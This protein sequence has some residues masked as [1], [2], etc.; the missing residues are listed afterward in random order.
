MFHFTAIW[1]PL[2][3]LALFMLGMQYM[4]TSINRLS[5]RSFKLFLKKY[6]S[7]KLSAIGGGTLITA[8]LQ[9]SSIVNLLVLA[10]V[11]A[12]VLKL[13]QA[14]SVILGANLGTTFTGWL[15][16]WLG[17]SYDLKAIALPLTAIGGLVMALTSREKK[18]FTVS[19]L[20]FSLGLIF[21]GL[22]FIKDGTFDIIKTGL[23]SGVSHY[24]LLV[25]AMAGFAFTSII[26]SSSATTAI[27]L[28]ALYAGAISLESSLAIALGSEIGT[29]TKLMLA[30]AGGSSSK[31]RVALGS[32]LFNIIP[33]IILFPFLHIIGTLITGQLG[34]S[35]KLL[36]LTAFQSLYNL[37]SI[38]IFLPV[39]SKISRYLE[40]L[41]KNRESQTLFLSKQVI[42]EPEVGVEAFRRETLHM[43]YDSIDLM[44]DAMG[45][46]TDYQEKNNLHPGYRDRTLLKKYEFIKQL[47]GRMREYFIQLQTA[48]DKPELAETL[49]PLMSSARNAL[50]AAK[51]MKDIFQDINML[52]GSSNNIK[53]GMYM[54]A[55]ERNRTLCSQLTTALADTEKIKEEKLLGIYQS[56]TDEYAVTLK[57]LYK[58]STEGHL[59]DSEIST[60]INFNR[61]LST[62]H[63]S[64][65]IAVKDFILGMESPAE[66]ENMPGF[67]R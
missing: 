1:Q 30:S 34:L 59:N 52:A 57:N 5:G 22:Q 45:D 35:N 53:Y 23:I 26:Q 49:E 17:F 64:I 58:E 39:L 6:S 13:Q 43:L 50:Y 38:L 46:K 36:A 37:F 32:L 48:S 11:G 3:G 4:E 10:F 62:A 20:V 21:I 67:I 60:M 44:R 25:F 31:K 56:V 27:I 61:E 18:L 29:A 40:S 41:Y 24:S 55:L 7:R 42:A 66:L 19:R 9:S 63:K 54:Q 14:L 12:G 65:F 15:I 8:I 33:A 16:A 28:S 47:H 51:S 2:A